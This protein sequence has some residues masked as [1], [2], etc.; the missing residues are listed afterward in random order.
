VSQRTARIWIV[1]GLVSSIV[2][3]ACGRG[4]ERP[5]P[6][7]GGPQVT[8]PPA[9]A[10]PQAPPPATG[11]IDIWTFP[12]GDD[13]KSLKAYIA[14]FK[15]QNPGSNP[16]LLVI[17][18]GDPYFQ[19]VNTALRARKPP[20]IAIIE[21]RAWMKVGR[22]VDLTPYYQAWGWKVEDF[23]PGGLARG[24]T[25]GDVS[26]GVYAV[27][28][29]LGGN[30]LFYNKKM[31][32]AASVPY[33]PTDRSLTIQE[34]VDICRKLAKPDPNPAKTVWGCS[35]PEFGFGIRSKD[36]FGEDGR[37]AEGNWNSP[38]M[39]EAWN[40]G[41]AL[42][43]DRMAP[44]PS[45]L[46]AATESDL[47]AQ[48]RMGITWSDF[49]EANKYKQNN[50]DF[51][52]APFF[53]IKQGESFVDTWTAPWGTFKDSKNPNGALAFLHFL[54]TRAQEMRIETSADP[55]LSTKVAQ[56]KN[57]GADDPIKQEYLKVLQHAQPQVFVPPGVDA[58]DPAEVLRQMTVER[59]TD[60]KPIL[61]DMAKKMQK[62]LD[63]SWAA[64]EKLGS[65]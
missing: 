25:E 60:A 11:T 8:P 53:V 48:N 55:P 3:G 29:F 26:K 9:G 37:K 10:S 2:V 13:E 44:A 20:D 35:M 61:D 12:Q 38:E 40:I 28:D 50:I 21:D 19:K 24:T 17:P 56:S 46:E 23:N 65:G 52:L 6:G 62:E 45:Q 47:F 15:K 27:G 58:W 57:Y 33:P 32:D 18:E 64:W 42:T 22:I 36:V 30:V 1:L 14:E 16:K 49:T 5:A 41:S 59:K 43:R 4:G 39:V 51:G 63:A 34:Y 31:F 54:G 7:G